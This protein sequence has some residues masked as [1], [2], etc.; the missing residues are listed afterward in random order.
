MR[1][2]S[3]CVWLVTNAVLLVGLAGCGSGVDAA[4]EAN[5]AAAAATTHGGTAGNELI[6][7][8]NAFGYTVPERNKLGWARQILT[9]AC[10]RRLGYS[11]ND[12]ADDAAQHERAVAVDLADHGSYGN[13]RRY[14]VTDLAIA[15][16]YGYHLVSTVTSTGRR[17]P[18]R[19]A[20]M[21]A[22][23]NEALTG[24]GAGGK[25]AT[26]GGN[27]RPVPAGGCISAA[28][29]DLADSGQV[30]EAKVVNQLDSRSYQQSLHDT[31]VTAAFRAWSTCM[32]SKGYNIADPLRAS[33]GFDLD[34][35]TVTAAEIATA[36]T[37][38][39][40]K[41]QTRL[42]DI[43]FSSEVAYQK[44]QIKQHAD[45]FHKARLEHDTVMKTVAKIVSGGH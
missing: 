21:K 5:R 32:A 3:C 17:N 24:F 10:M 8:I 33:D 11:Y 15:G 2:K 36:R 20:P 4:A 22:A 37:D 30:G 45:Q 25:P 41:Q 27:G 19:A 18:Q 39:S 13:K 29:A 31:K 34:T 16:W 35:R 28:D 38:V 7:P 14:A 1:T 6:L 40:C 12:A 44:M 23:E 42:T 26:R 9:G 43:W